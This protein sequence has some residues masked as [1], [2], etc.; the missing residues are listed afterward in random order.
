MSSNNQ[1]LTAS[2]TAK[3]SN[4]KSL[5]EAFKELEKSK[6]QVKQPKLEI[7]GTST[8]GAQLATGTREPPS[9][10]PEDSVSMIDYV[11]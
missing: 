3:V 4:L 6:N 10:T 7:N 5:S 11:D 1:L 2:L 9:Y 8:F